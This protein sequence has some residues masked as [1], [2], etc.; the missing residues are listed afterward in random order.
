MRNCMNEH[1]NQRFRISDSGFSVIELT[2][3]LALV[4]IMTMIA[5]GNLKAVRSPALE[6]ANQTMGFFKQVRAKALSTTS[7]YFVSA[8]S[9]TRLVTSFGIN[10]SDASPVADSALT[11]DL[12]SGA[13][14]TDITWNVCFTPRGF[15]DSTAIIPVVDGEGGAES[16]ELY[17][18]G[19]VRIQ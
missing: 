4:G 2:V 13:S 12:P 7:A 18:G 5:A 17:L 8:A 15:P 6:A 19:A 9:P 3:A 10:C 11:L 16:V 1:S 14:M